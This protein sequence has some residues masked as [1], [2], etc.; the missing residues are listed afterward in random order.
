MNP[1]L[2]D[3]TT[4]ELAA[5]VTKNFGITQEEAADA[6]QQLSNAI[7]Y[8]IERNMLSR[9]GVAD[10]TSLLV[11][12]NVG[13]V[14][15]DA[16][17]DAGN[18]ILDVLIGSKHVSRGIAARAASQ[19]GVSPDA[20]EGMLPLVANAVIGTL[21]KEA[22]S[23][24]QKIV[25]GLDSGN[26]LPLPGELPAATGNSGQ[27][28][29]SAT[30]ARPDYGNPLP[31]PG[32]IARP[33][34]RQGRNVDEQPAPQPGGGADDQDDGQDGSDPYQRLPDIV[35]RGGTPAPGGGGSIEDVIRNILGSLL[36]SGNRG[37][38]GTMI[39]LFIVRFLAS[40]VRRIFS[41]LGG[42]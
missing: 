30:P 22:G 34:R 3:A 42:R 24:L 18:N 38:V 36:G 15:A 21:R 16:S 39:Q 23:S 1:I 25:Y 5:S 17:S 19:S 9:G 35:R 27:T 2:S 11:N 29:N 41:Q 33:A 14:Q 20:A 40:L 32:E 13:T 37:V 7:G 28:S 4:R 26:S 6:I 31:I 12:P 10:V 8:R